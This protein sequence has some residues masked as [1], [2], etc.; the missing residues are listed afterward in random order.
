MK[1]ILT[2]C[3]CLL[4]PFASA[5]A[6]AADPLADRG[7]ALIQAM[8]ELAESET[9]CR[10]MGASEEMIDLMRQIGAADYGAPQSVYRVTFDE[11]RL[12][13]LLGD[14]P[15]S[16][17][18]EGVR[19]RLTERCYSALSTQLCAFD[20]AL[21]LATASILT[22]SDAFLDDSLRENALYVYLYGGDWSATVT[23]V[24][25]DESIVL[26][27]AQFVPTHVLT[28]LDDLGF[29]DWVEADACTIETIQ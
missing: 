9:Y 27:T 4:L 15:V 12:P 23:C 28:D 3:L 2:L 17:L 25:Q 22:A 14:G 26:A 16:D 18:P 6:E 21:T 13:A 8:D 20:G 7:L 29:R 1:T 5:F 19:R 10:A 11:D 24:V